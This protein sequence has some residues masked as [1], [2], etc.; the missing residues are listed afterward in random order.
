[1]KNKILFISIL[2]FAAIVP[3]ALY[4]KNKNSQKI[5]S[6]QEVNEIIEDV[7][8][9]VS[10]FCI[11]TQE[12]KFIE[13]C[14]G[15]PTYGEIT[16]DSLA[17]LLHDLAL[18]KHDH[19]YDLGSGVGKVCVQAALTT[20]ARATGIELSPTRCTGAEQIKQEL[21]KRK[22]LTNP[23]KLKFI[24]QNIAD[25]NLS[26]ATAI[27]MCSTCFSEE[28]M[29]LLVNKMVTE[30]KN[31]LRVL[32]LKDLP[33]NNHFSFIKQYELPMT[34]SQNSPVYL[35]QLIK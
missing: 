19:F 10:G 29:N 4:L 30:C 3:T 21:I 12:R 11:E 9:K 8:C 7:Y 33:S 2:I 14:G 32:T 17:L 1:M 15:N 25:V 22:I 35:Y 28:L 16:T 18:T 13:D 27:F 20:P 24:E 34:W 5:Y 31:G 26:D 6:T 23:D